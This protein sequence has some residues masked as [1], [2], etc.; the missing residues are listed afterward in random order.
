MAPTDKAALVV[1]FVALFVLPA[2]LGALQQ[3]QEWQQ[4][5]ATAVAQL[6]T[7]TPLP[8]YW[9]PTAAEPTATP[10]LLLVATPD[11]TRVARAQ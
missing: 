3:A 6:A 1:L 10:Y 8:T 7:A 11:P 2:A 5:Q 9:L 4:V